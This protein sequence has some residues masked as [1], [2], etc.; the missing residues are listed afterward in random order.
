MRQRA[1]SYLKLIF[2]T[3]LIAACSTTARRPLENWPVYRV[4]VESGDTLAQIADKYDTTWQSIAN[5]NDVSDPTSLEVGQVLQ[6][7]PGPG[8]LV[9]GYGLTQYRQ[10]RKTGLY[11]ATRPAT[12]SQ[13][14]SK[15]LLFGSGGSQAR[16]SKGNLHW[17][18]TGD[19]SSYYG[20]R[21][22]RMHHGIDIKARRGTPIY[23]PAGGKIEFVGRKR[24]YGKTVIV[25]HG[26]MKTLYAHC[27]SLHVSRGQTVS[28]KKVIARVGRTGNATGSHLHFE[29][30]VSG[31]TQDP[32]PWLRTKDFMSSILGE[33]QH[34]PYLFESD[35]PL[36]MITQLFCSS[37]SCGFTWGD[38]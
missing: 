25:N 28:A 23:A 10:A 37:E 14:P 15:G 11:K 26:G 21:W 6:V 8:G 3:V 5:L 36:T 32:L 38:S 12:R 34:K 29:V 19:I 35:N 17:P 31:K 9:P 20:R 4:K 30:R 27:N 24:G 7:V 22:G 33:P 13:R 16:T 2:L 18:V 1:T